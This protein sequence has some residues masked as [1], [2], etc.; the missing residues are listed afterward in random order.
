VNVLSLFD[1][2]SCGRV[3]LERAGIDVDN[4]Y[5]SE[6]D[7][8]AIQ[9]AQK[10]YPDTI[11]LGSV[12]DWRDWDIGQPD[13][14][15]GGSPCQGFS[16]AGKGLNF[17]DP[18]SKL[19]FVFI[20]AL[21]HYKPKYFLLEN[22]KM[23][24]EW[25]NV[26]TDMTGVEPIDINSALV[27]AQNRRRL[28]W[29]NIPGVGQP[30]DKGIMLKDIVHENE[31]VI[32]TNLDDYKVPVTK[33]LQIMDEEVKR[34]KIG[35]FRKD[36][37]ANRVYKIHGKAV[38]LC[39]DAGGGAAKMGQYLFGCMTPDRIKKRQNG[40]R[41]SKGEKSYT[42][43]A[44]DKHGILIDGYIRKLTP[45]ECERLQTLPDG[46][47]GGVSNSQRYKCL[48]NCWTVDV[49]SHIL[50]NIR[51]TPIMAQIDVAIYDQTLH[52]V[53]KAL[54]RIK[55]MESPRHYLGMSAIGHECPRNLFYSF[56]N[57]A[58]N[59]IDGAGAKRIEDGHTQ[60]PIMADRLRLLPYIE[61]HTMDPDKP[62]R[63]IGFQLLLGHFR[64]HCDGIIRG[65]IESP[66]TWHVW[67][68]KSVNEK[69]FNKLVKLRQTVGEK[70]ALMEWNVVYFDQAQ[71]YMHEAGLTRHY[72]TVTTPGGRDYTSIRTE[73]SKSYAEAII[74]KA[75]G[76][77]F[78]NWVLPEGISD[79]REFFKCKW[80][81]FQGHCHDG[82]IPLVHCK[83]CR[84]SEPVKDGKRKCTFKDEL[85][86]DG[87]L[88]VG[89]DRHIFNPALIQAKLIE[90]QE[91]GCLYHI[92][93][94]DIFFSNTNIA[95]FPDLKGRC[96]AIYTSQDLKEKIKSISNITKETVKLQGDFK[97]EVVEDP[98]KRWNKT[99]KLKDV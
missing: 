99:S 30:E 68:H 72:L 65:I 70:K 95:G 29:T 79:K 92:E 8:Y 52:E 80:C 57:V 17:D 32:E 45:I 21:K 71:I 93:T 39:G 91:D 2:I 73:Y 54:E 34:N 15:I 49:I 26:I 19:F 10:N 88:N 40:Q 7:K 51:R 48:G 14:I 6:V 81:Q 82:D 90:H 61:L 53:D 94:A 37:Q 11:Q 63:Q 43:T 35:Y 47:T 5:A 85:I 1:G 58:P 55:A 4:Y 33:E 27:S 24:K 46:Y 77:I 74:E 28:Y 87:M 12:E 84:Y 60:E 22:V 41:F 13:I 31:G 18:R 20:D 23:K 76:I 50:Q 98:E 64:G 66:K 97:G 59:V 38:T 75:Q 44:Q 62:D 16:V 78:D 25:Q 89:C 96:D 86:D 56:R 3:A 69:S 67:E 83:T 36:C 9:V 42:M